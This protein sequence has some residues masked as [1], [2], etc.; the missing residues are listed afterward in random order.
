MSQQQQVR[1]DPWVAV[2]LG[3]VGMLEAQFLL[4]L[5]VSGD[6]CWEKERPDKGGQSYEEGLSPQAKLACGLAVLCADRVIHVLA[7]IT[8]SHHHPVLWEAVDSHSWRPAP[9]AQAWLLVSP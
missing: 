2:S 9:G 3:G 4:S 7:C 6:L 1:Q 5:G 8:A